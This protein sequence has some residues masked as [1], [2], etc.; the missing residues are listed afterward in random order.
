MVKVVN[1]A[2]LKAP[3]LARRFTSGCGPTISSRLPVLLS[4]LDMPPGMT[5]SG[6]V[7]PYV[8]S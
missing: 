7:F 3:H 2:H 4:K 6:R 5:V 8:K 1:T